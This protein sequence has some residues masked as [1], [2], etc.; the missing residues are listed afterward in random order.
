MIRWLYG[1]MT[2]VLLVVLLAATA[3]ACLVVSL[4]P[5]YDPD[6]LVWDPALVGT[7]QSTDDETT[8]EIEQDEWR[9]YRIQYR[10]PIEAG[11]LTGYLAAVGDERFMDVMPVRGTDRGAFVLPLHAVARVRLAEGRLEL[12][13]LSY[14]WF[15]DRAK[16][17]N[18]IGK[19]SVTIDHKQNIVLVSPPAAVRQWLAGQAK[20][21]E[22]F[23]P[24]TVF[25]KK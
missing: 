20:D 5:V 24:A 14:D 23:G 9:S 12:T 16:E 15:L 21:G 19:L 10:H 13:P 25:V 11:E 6:A 17:G 4:Q 2:R 8:L 7:W 3:P 18:A 22:M 1:S